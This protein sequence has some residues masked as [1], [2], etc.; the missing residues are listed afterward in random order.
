MN[1]ID[2]EHTRHEFSNTVIDIFIDDFVDLETEFLSDFSLFRSVDLGHEGEEVP[3]AL[4][5]RVRHVQI[6]KSDVLNDFFLFVDIAF[7]NGNVLLR[8]QIELSG[9]GVRST[10]SFDSAGGRLDIDNITDGYFLF[11]D[12]LVDGGV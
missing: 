9:V 5:S 2:K 6:M 12:V 4:W 3:T 7:G 11:L 8:L 10:D 1:L